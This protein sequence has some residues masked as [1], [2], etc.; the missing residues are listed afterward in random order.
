MNV[1]ITLQKREGCGGGNWI[2]A[3][4][5]A[6]GLTAAG[7]RVRLVAATDVTGDDLGWADV[8]HGMH[9]L[10][11][12]APVLPHAR[13]VGKPVVVTLTGTD[14]NHGLADP[15]TAPAVDA[16]LQA[17]RRI[18]V[19]HDGQKEAVA[20]TRP[21]V[22][23]KLRVIPPGVRLPDA[24]GWR[25]CYWGLEEGDFAF[26]FLGNL[27]LVKDPVFAIE[28]LARLQRR[29]PR[30][31]LLLAGGV[32]EEEAEEAVNQALAG[33]PWI[34]HLGPV[35]H[36]QITDLILAADVLMNTSLSEGL[37][38]ALL[39]GM[40]LGLPVLARDVPGNR[41]L[42]RPGR[43]GLLFRDADEFLIQAERLLRDRPYREWLGRQARRDVMAR[44]DLER[45]T[46]GHLA[47][48]DEVTGGAA[49]WSEAGD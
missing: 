28:P 22:L 5:L 13:R 4:R 14:L 39:E 49:L 18:L 1:L 34:R 23:P 24:R 2:S 19:Y 42:I 33:R 43:T 12:A 3:E 10:K 48:Y 31:R 27:R 29:Y 21:Q 45:E 30:L 20:R 25:R 16:V 35:P 46:A 44:F 8:I 37:S 15:A 7:R 11:G 17:A 47:V 9:A 38:N 40:S 36:D 26:L 41:E 6:A 32:L